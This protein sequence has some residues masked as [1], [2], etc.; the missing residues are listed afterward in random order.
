MS[1]LLRLGGDDLGADLSV[2]R[3][4]ND[5]LVHEIRLGLVRPAVNDLLRI[6]VADSGQRAEVCFAGRVDVYQCCG[7][8]GCGLRHH[9]VTDGRP[10]ARLGHGCTAHK[11]QR[12]QYGQS[13]L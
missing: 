6:D 7:R 13:F 3:L 4:G 2:G 5:L 8:R 11:T 12:Q 1:F 9:G 10:R